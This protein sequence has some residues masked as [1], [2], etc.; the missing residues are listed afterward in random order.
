MKVALDHV[1]FDE[2]FGQRSR[3]VRARIVGDAELAVEVV[4]RQRQRAR[5]HSAHFTGADLL[6]LAQFNP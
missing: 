4:D 6:D 3:A 1:V 2:P 5:F